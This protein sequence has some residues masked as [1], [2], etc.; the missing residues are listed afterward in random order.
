MALLT[1]AL[2]GTVFVY[3]GEELGLLDVDL[4]DEVLQ[5]PRWARSGGTDRGRD[6]YR[7][8]MPWEGTAPGYGFTTGD[9]VAAD[10][11]RVRRAGSSPTSWRTRRRRSRCTAARSS[12]AAATPA[13][14][15]TDVEWFGAPPGCL[16][17]RR[18]GRRWCAR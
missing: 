13:S 2:P 5:D 14:P 8:P 4:P 11:R 6:G 12:C 18:S 15:A 3:N 9:A 7:V 17:F 1:L 10:A 16:A